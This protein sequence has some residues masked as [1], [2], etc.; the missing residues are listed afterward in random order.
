MTLNS[1]D[2]KHL[3]FKYDDNQD[4]YTLEDLSFH[5]KHTLPACLDKGNNTSRER[6][7]KEEEQLKEKPLPKKKR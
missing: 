3:K 5:V 4:N 2:V 1:I 6:G 7:E